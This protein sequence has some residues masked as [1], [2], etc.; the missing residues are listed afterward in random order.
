MAA[1]RDSVLQVHGRHGEGAAWEGDARAVAQVLRQH[2]A[3]HGGAHQAHA[4]LA[5][6][7]AAAAAAAVV[8]VAV[9]ADAV[10]VD[11]LPL[12][13]VAQRQQKE[14]PLDCALMH[15]IHEHVGDAT[16]GG[17]ALEP[18]QQHA[19]GAEE[20]LRRCGGAALT[21]HRVPHGARAAPLATLGRDALGDADGGDAPRLRDND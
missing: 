12:E 5:G 14:V 7:A 10:T 19:S 16:E 18:A 20:Q 3:I 1:E 15:L 13:K 4:Q 8:V 11:R 2:G 17:I 21:A 6:A 9:V